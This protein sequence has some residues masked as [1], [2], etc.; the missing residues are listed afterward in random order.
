MTARTFFE[1]VAPRTLAAVPHL[2]RLDATYQFRVADVAGTETWTLELTDRPNCA[3][4]AG[5]R[6]DCT[7]SIGCA[8]FERLLGNPSCGQ[9]LFQAGRIGI[10]GRSELAMQVPGLLRLLAKGGSSEGFGA[11]LGATP[12]SRFRNEYWP[13]RLFVHH[14]VLERVGVLASVDGLASVEALLEV[15]PGRVRLSDEQGGR[16]VDPA[17]ARALYGR[18]FH[19]AF[20]DVERVFPVLASWLEEIRWELDLPINAFGR[21]HVYASPDA[22]GEVAHFDANVNFVLQ[23]HGEKT[24]RVAPNHHVKWPTERYTSAAPHSS[25]ALRTYSSGTLPTALPEDAESIKLVPGSFLVMPRGYWHET[26]AHGSSLSLNFTFD[27]PS[28][29][30]VL[31]P[32]IHRQLIRHEHWRELASGAGAARA[33]AAAGARERLA[34]LIAGLARDLRDLDAASAIAQLTP[35]ESAEPLNRQREHT[36]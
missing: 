29:A 34:A 26:R 12:V 2:F 8:D 19:L 5:D 14:G 36:S 11:L 1:D 15:W 23:L 32:E 30:D 33:E 10:T 22:R 20:G 4:R 25:E 7:I 28:W 9:Q 3:P 13:D 16:L 17:Q 35:S 21:C 6:A 31:M 24:W 18:G 27:Q